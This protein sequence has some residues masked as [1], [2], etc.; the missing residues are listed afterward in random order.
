MTERVLSRILTALRLTGTII[1][2]LLFVVECFDAFVT[3]RPDW[4]WFAAAIALIL[5]CRSPAR[6]VEIAS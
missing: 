2:L 3:P 6:T 4:L 1:G 5:L